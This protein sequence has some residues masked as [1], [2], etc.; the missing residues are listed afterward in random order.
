MTAFIVYI[1]NYKY[2][3]F[4]GKKFENTLTETMQKELGN[5]IISLHLGIESKLPGDGK[6][7]YHK[8]PKINQIARK[9]VNNNCYS[10]FAPL[11]LGIVNS[12]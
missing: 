9:L 8:N 3:E 5:Q 6:Q 12:E 11:I 7:I 4:I 10:I 2:N 1:D